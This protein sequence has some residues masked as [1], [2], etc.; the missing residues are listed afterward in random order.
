MKNSFLSILF[1]VLYFASACQ[2][3]QPPTLVTEN[4]KLQEQVNK[5]DELIDALIDFYSDIERDLEIISEKQWN[6]SGIKPEDPKKKKQLSELSNRLQTDLQDLHN[7]MQNNKDKMQ[8]LKERLE[9]RSEQM[10]KIQKAFQSLHQK[11]EKK[12]AE[13]ILLRTELSGVSEEYVKVFDDYL[14]KIDEADSLREQGSTLYFCVGTKK[15]FLQIKMME[16]SSNGLKIIAFPNSVEWATYCKTIEIQ[17][18]VIFNIAAKKI[19]IVS[20]HPKNS[21]T[22]HKSEDKNIL[23]QILLAKEFWSLSD[24]LMVVIEK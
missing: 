20:H 4:Q 24:Y 9:L 8:A 11:V 23:I 14:K 21:Y 13:I 22:I 1:S 10:E 17:E 5:K 7:L 2:N 15:E 6:I 3:R 12:E 16:D 19:N 18:N